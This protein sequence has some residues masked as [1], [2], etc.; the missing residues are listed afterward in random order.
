MAMFNNWDITGGASDFWTYVREPR[1]HRWALWG[2]ACTIAALVFW[3]I[4]EKLI[5]FEAPKSSIVY[6]E[7]WRANRSDAEVRADWIERA[8]ETTRRNAERRRNYQA[9]A[10]SLGVEYDA[11]E[12]DKVTRETLGTAA[13]D[14][15]KRPEVKRSTLA[16]RAARAAPPPAR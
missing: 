13:D 16:E 6:F 15:G 12:A 11:D 2:L 4:S 5:T 10:K 7:S 8:K 3:V 9:L 14:I 1:P